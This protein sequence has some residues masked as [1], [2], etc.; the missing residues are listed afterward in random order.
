MEKQANGTKEQEQSV[1]IAV[2]NEDITEYN[3]VNQADN[4]NGAPANP[5]CCTRYV[6]DIHFITYFVHHIAS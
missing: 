3:D 4:P 2:D 1:V 6:F 5:T